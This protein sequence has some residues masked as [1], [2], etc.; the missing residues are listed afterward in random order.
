MSLSYQNMNLKKDVQRLTTKEG[1]LENDVKNLK[2]D[3]EEQ[4]F[5]YH[6]LD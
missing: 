5:Q 6:L 1:K 4:K 3:L 2:F